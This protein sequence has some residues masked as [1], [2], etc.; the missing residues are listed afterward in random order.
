MANHGSLA[1]ALG[2]TL[3]AVLMKFAQFKDHICAALFQTA[4]KSRLAPL[5]NLILSEAQRELGYFDR[6]IA[7]IVGLSQAKFGSVRLAVT[8]SVAQVILPPV[9]QRFINDHP[10]VQIDL[11]DMDSAA[12]AEE[13]RKGCADIGFDSIAAPAG[14]ERQHFFSDAFGVVY[15]SDHSITQNWDTLNWADLEDVDFIANGLC[16]QITDERFQPILAAARLTVRNTASL[17]GLVQA[18]VGLTLLPRLVALPGFGDLSFLPLRSAFGAPV[19]VD[20]PVAPS[21]GPVRS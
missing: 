14:F 4:R 3:S 17:L 6:T 12:V 21:F 10:N 7:A 20:D 8:P 19:G 15:R 18:G 9:L 1:A 5:K 16:H 13:L 2:R 11:R